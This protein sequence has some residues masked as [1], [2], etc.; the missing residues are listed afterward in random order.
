M[1]L[2]RYPPL[3]RPL[4]VGVRN[5]SGIVLLCAVFILIVSCFDVYAYDLQT[6]SYIIIF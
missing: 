3:C 6:A 5:F 2:V 1:E 4:L